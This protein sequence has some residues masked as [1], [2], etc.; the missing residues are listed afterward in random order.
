MR[1]EV[2]GCERK[3]VGIVTVLFDLI[4]KGKQVTDFRL[5]I[6]PINSTINGSYFTTSARLH[7]GARAM[8]SRMLWAKYLAVKKKNKLY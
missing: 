2:C 7:W 1:H 6:E 5:L 3:Y 4:T 8:S